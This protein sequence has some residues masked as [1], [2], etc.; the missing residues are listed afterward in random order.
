MNGLSY[1]CAEPSR[2]EPSRAEPSGPEDWYCDVTAEG[3]RRLA[4]VAETTRS[5][6]L[7]R[8]G[9][10]RCG[11]RRCG[12]APLRACAAV[13]LRRCGPAPLCAYGF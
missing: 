8:I 5:A 1:E 13:G 2:A 10:D 12:P 11:L 4:G 9:S 3:M 7:D 6:A